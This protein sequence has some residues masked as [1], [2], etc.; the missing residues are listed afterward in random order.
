MRQGKRIREGK[1]NNKYKG[2]DKDKVKNIKGKSETKRRGT[3]RT[4]ARIH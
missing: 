3:T 2:I 4:R 1:D